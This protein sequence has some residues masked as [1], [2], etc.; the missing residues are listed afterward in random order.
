[1]YFST[2]FVVWPFRI[3]SWGRSILFTAKMCHNDVWGP[4]K[5]KCFGHN[6]KIVIK[7]KML[8][9]GE[10]S[11]FHIPPTIVWKS[12][13]FLCVWSKTFRVISELYLA[14]LFFHRDLKLQCLIKCG[15]TWEVQ[16]P[17]CSWG[18]QP[19]E[20]RECASPK[21]N[22]P[23]CWSPPWTSTLSR[24]SLVTPWKSVGTWIPKAMASPHL[25]DPH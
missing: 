15:P 19:K 14:P 16:S 1:M 10:V 25:K 13:A 21:G 9:D 24:E 3:A 18:L 12:P 11:V 20:W 22:T 17:Q 2:Y 6:N 23:T 4:C 7:D 8:K 5:G